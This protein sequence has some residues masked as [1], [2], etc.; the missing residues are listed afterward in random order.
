MLSIQLQDV[1]VSREA[2]DS[3]THIVMP[4]GGQCLQGVHNALA[5]VSIFSKQNTF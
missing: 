4:E 2:N 3:G 5:D 1:P